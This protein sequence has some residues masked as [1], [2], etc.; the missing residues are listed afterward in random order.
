MLFPLI[1]LFYIPSDSRRAHFPVRF[2]LFGKMRLVLIAQPLRD[3]PDGEIRFFQK[4]AGLFHP[5]LRDHL[6][7]RPACVLLEDPINLGGVQAHAVGQLGHGNLAAD[8]SPDVIHGLLKA[9]E[10]AALG[11]E[12]AFLLFFLR[13]PRHEKIKLPRDVEHIFSS[14]AFFIDVLDAVLQKRVL[15]IMKDQ[16]LPIQTASFRIASAFRPKKATQQRSQGSS[17]SAV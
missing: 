12:E 4:F 9:R 3:V 10:L 7:R 1:P 14:L 16:V 8:I 6:L 2:E 17:L 11:T 13:Q 5:K 15:I